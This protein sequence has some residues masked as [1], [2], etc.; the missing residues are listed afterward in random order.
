MKIWI[1]ITNLWIIALLFFCGCTNVGDNKERITILEATALVEPKLMVLD[2]VNHIVN[3]I[4]ICNC[5]EYEVCMNLAI[6]NLQKGDIRGG[7]AHA[8]NLIVLDS[9]DGRGFVIKSVAMIKLEQHNLLY[10]NIIRAS[11]L[12]EKNK[13]GSY[14]IVAESLESK[15][16]FCFEN[17][18]LVQLYI[19][20][21]LLIPHLDSL[22]YENLSIFRPQ[23]PTP[24][25]WTYPDSL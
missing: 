6:D 21:D 19:I 13:T 17:K 2:S 24:F 23:E 4:E 7:K 9:M 18:S 20:A 15:F 1:Q 22:E 10:Y 8:N 14:H 12:L 25:M 16:R 11:K 3:P 5:L